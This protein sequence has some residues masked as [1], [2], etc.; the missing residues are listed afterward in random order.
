MTN[1]GDVANLI[2]KLE[3]EG[4]RLEKALKSRDTVNMTGAQL[5]I[6]FVDEE[7]QTKIEKIK[8][9]IKHVEVIA[10]DSSYHNKL[11]RVHLDLLDEKIRK[12]T[13]A[14][15]AMSMRAIMK[16]ENKNKEYELRIK[17]L[18]KTNQLL[19]K[20]LNRSTLSTPK[21]RGI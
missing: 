20:A 3:A 4:L 6:E 2:E 8:V 10:P 7:L 21:N 9:K 5:F 11:L 1:P 19:R 18:E 17:E 16:L 12:G 15:L 14:T 13:E